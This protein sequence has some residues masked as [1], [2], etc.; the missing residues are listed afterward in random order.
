MRCCRERA[1]TSNGLQQRQTSTASYAEPPP[2][3]PREKQE[4]SSEEVVRLKND[5]LEV[6]H[7]QKSERGY[8]RWSRIMLQLRTAEHL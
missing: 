7:F 1:A 8:K 6:T 5:F 3:H 4:I 2:A